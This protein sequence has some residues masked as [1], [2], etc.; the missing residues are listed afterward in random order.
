LK[1]CNKEG[2]AR[3]TLQSSMVAMALLDTL[4]FKGFI[5]TLDA[6]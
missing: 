2:N 5:I 3:T 4:V 1:E 6:F